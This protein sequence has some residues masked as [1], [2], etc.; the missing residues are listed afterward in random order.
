MTTNPHLKS[1]RERVERVNIKKVERVKMNSKKR[2]KMIERGS[3]F[4]RR[5]KREERISAE[6]GRE[7]SKRVNREKG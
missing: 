4:S 7:L 5:V 6:R 1:E 3:E 2:G